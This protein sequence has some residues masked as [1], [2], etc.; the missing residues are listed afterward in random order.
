MAN[1]HNRCFP[2]QNYWFLIFIELNFLYIQVFILIDTNNFSPQCFI[3]KYRTGHRILYSTLFS[4]RIKPQGLLAQTATTKI[5]VAASPPFCL[6]MMWVPQ[7][8]ASLSQFLI[9]SQAPTLLDILCSNTSHAS[10]SC[11]LSMDILHSVCSPEAILKVTTLDVTNHI[12]LVP[13]S[14]SF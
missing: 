9:V 7:T 8:M 4:P 3:N 10:Q 5:P 13:H 6:C 1:F 2:D 14:S 12:P 11:R